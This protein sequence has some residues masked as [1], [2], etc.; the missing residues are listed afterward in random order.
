MDRLEFRIHSPAR[1]DWPRHR[2][3]RRDGGTWWSRGGFGF[4]IG[5]KTIPIPPPALLAGIFLAAPLLFNAMAPRVNGV[6]VEG[7]RILF[8]E[9]VSGSMSSS[10]PELAR[11]K[12]L[13]KN[14]LVPGGVNVNG[15]G[16]ISTGSENLRSALESALPARKDIDAVYFFSDFY[17]ATPEWDCDDAPGLDRFRRLIR[18][19]GVRLYLSTV[20]RMPSPGLLAI[21]R[22]SGGGLTGASAPAESAQLRATVCGNRQ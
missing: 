21:A 5:A 15:F 17:P 4:E 13:L 3:L 6:A 8:V 20:N 9:D 2:F 12:A 22:E 18:Q 1:Q 16:V 11:Q 19:T 7:N 14:T 10:Q